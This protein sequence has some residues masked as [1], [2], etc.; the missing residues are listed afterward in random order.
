MPSND[1]YLKYLKTPGGA[2][3]GHH[4]NTPFKEDIPRGLK[5]KK[6]YCALDHE[7]WQTKKTKKT[8]FLF[9]QTNLTITHISQKP[10]KS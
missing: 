8:L 2:M 4:H 9:A 6:Q 7:L 10:W 5:P 3:S 1:M